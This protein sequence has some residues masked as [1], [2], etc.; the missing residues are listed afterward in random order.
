[1]ETHERAATKKCSKCGIEKPLSDFYA[2]PRTRCKTCVLEESRERYERTKDRVL[3]RC[4]EYRSTK[5]ESIKSYLQGWYERNKD[6]VLERCKQYRQ[7]PEVKERERERSAERYAKKRDEIQAQRKAYYEAHPD[8]KE[9]F[10]EY[11]KQHYEGNKPLYMAN[12]ARRRSRK[13]CATPKW[14]DAKAILEIYKLAEQLTLAT[15]TKHEVDHIVPLQGRNVCGL[16]VEN[17][18]RV[19]TVTEN[20]RKFNKHHG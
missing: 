8:A 1:M 9:R 3:A 10:R 20:R 7:K 4:A 18:L 5:S 12:C 13:L 14:A 16:H 11:A 19:V 17:N 6:H 15:G 2:K